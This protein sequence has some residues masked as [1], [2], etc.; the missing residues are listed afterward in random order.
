M[1]PLGGNQ[2]VH[3]LWPDFTPSKVASFQESFYVQPYFA[4]LR[5]LCQLFF[6]QSLLGIVSTRT[7]TRNRHGC[8]PRAACSGSA[9]ITEAVARRLAG[10]R[11]GLGALCAFPGKPWR[12]P[13]K[14]LLSRH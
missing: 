3:L 14:P 9:E 11:P 6:R 13:E 2:K 12:F 4:L 5:P 10:S 8:G 1:C 7:W